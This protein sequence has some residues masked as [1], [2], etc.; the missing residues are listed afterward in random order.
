MSSKPDIK[1]ETYT[2]PAPSAGEKAAQKATNV[3]YDVDVPPIVQGG[4]GVHADVRIDTNTD[5]PLHISQ[6]GKPINGLPASFDFVPTAF[7][8]HVSNGVRNNTIQGEAITINDKD[9]TAIKD[10]LW[11][12]AVKSHYGKDATLS[13]TDEENK[14]NVEALEPTDEDV[15]SEA[16]RLGKAEKKTVFQDYNDVRGLMQKGNA[17][18]KLIDR[19]IDRLKNKPVSESKST[20]STGSGSD[21][22]IVV[23]KDGKKFRL[24][25]TQLNEAIKQGYKQSQ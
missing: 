5:K 1:Y 8:S 24:P 16:V 19:E 23:E 25:K 2:P 13:P 18:T 11:L 15:A 17:N 9:K 14:K 22:K 7:I 20:V 10:N 6:A 4:T 3:Q 21:D 12:N